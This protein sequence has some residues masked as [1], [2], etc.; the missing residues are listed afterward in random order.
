MGHVT[1]VGGCRAT[2]PSADILLG[3]IAEGQVVKIN[4]NGTPTEFYVAKH[5]Y[6]PT[7]NGTGRTCLIRKLLYDYR[8]WNNT[9][10]NTYANSSI[11]VW[12]NGPYKD[13][14]D[15][16]A[17][18]LIGTT[19]FYFTPGNANMTVRTL[20][21]AVFLASIAELGTSPTYANVEGSAFAMGGL[22]PATI[23]GNAENQWT[24]S[25]DI[26]DTAH[27]CIGSFLGGGGIL[28]VIRTDQGCSRPCFTLPN[29][30]KFDRRTLLLVG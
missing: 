8:Q 16:T 7:L 12:L 21:R 29:T 9:A 22:I 5:N 27:A 19:K 14:L 24:R 4:E 25:P 23:N 13:L 18:G 11:D 30:A 26:S 15:S 6:E 28:E 17:R 2:K 1:V 20:E 10:V 3:N